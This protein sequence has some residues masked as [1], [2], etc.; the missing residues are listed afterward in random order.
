MTKLYRLSAAAAMAAML[1]CSDTLGPDTTPPVP[2][3]LQATV[4][5]PFF[6]LPLG[7]TQVFTTQTANGVELDSVTVLALPKTVN[8]FAATEVHDRARVAGSLT[9]DTYDWF[10]QDPDGNVWYLGEDTKQYENGTLVGTE[11]TWQWGVNGATPGIIM[12]GDT[13]G[14]VGKLYRQEFD[15]GNAQDVGKVVAFNQSVTVPYGTFTGCIKTEEW[16]TL[17]SGPHDNKFYCPQLGTVLEI[18]SG[19]STKLVSVSP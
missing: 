19:D 11:G 13:T 15:R 7:M 18:A 16:S 2:T 5:N 12:W 1:A 17:E 8:G 14:T 4:N 10:A 6:P 3:T 9:E